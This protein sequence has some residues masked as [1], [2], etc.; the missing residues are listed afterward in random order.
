VNS[1]T[2]NPV[3]FITVVQ[4]YFDQKLELILPELQSLHHLIDVELR[5]FNYD[6]NLEKNLKFA[7]VRVKNK[8]VQLESALGLSSHARLKRKNLPQ[9][10]VKD[11][12]EKIAA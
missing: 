5:N 8:I 11:L 4:A 7:K 12:L 3:D 10:S 6:S 9:L 1:Q 2:N